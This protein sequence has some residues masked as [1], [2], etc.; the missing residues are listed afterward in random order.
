MIALT[1]AAERS[2]AGARRV[3]F[4]ARAVGAAQEIRA[5]DSRKALV[6]HTGG[7]PAFLRE[8]KRSWKKLYL[9]L[10]LDLPPRRND[11]DV[12]GRGAAAE[13]VASPWTSTRVK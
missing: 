8:R 10:P 13:R 1:G 3:A 11:R 7:Y 9:T 2:R 12:T 5:P 6:E 4:G